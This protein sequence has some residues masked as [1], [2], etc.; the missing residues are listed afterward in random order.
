LLNIN[1]NSK[2]LIYGYGV[3]GKS[4][5]QYLINKKYN[6]KIYDDLIFDNKNKNFINYNKVIKSLTSIDYFIVSPSIKINKSHFLYNFKKKIIID[7][8]FLSIE[9]KN[10][11]IIGITGTEGKSTICSYLHQILSKY[12]NTVIIGNFG[13]TILE[14]KDLSNFLSKTEIIIIELSSYQLDKIQNLKLDYAIITNIYND[15]IKYHSTL[16]KYIDAKLKISSFLIKEGFFFAPKIYIDKKKYPKAIVIPNLSTNKKDPQQ[17]INF[18][19]KK[20]IRVFMKNFDSKINYNDKLL[21]ELSFRNQL[22]ISRKKL[23]IYND[24]KCTNLEN[25]II[26]INLLKNLKKILVLGGI[27]K[28]SKTLPMPIKNTLV[29]IFGVHAEKISNLI[30]LKNSTSIL[31]NRLDDLIDFI[32]ISIKKYN[33]EI[34]LFSPGGES[35]DNYKNY[36]DRGLH[37]NQLL[38]SSKI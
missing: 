17:S 2:F 3:S 24:S 14:K 10:Q 22:V 29:L 12:Y 20:L 34:I 15:H 5:E 37:F 8:D 16:K 21:K 36:A 13:N 9:I 28:V 7:L 25:A 6:F 11:K 19:N 30:I 33:Y 4:I 18:N 27:P 23:K 32:S 1:K 31:F 35:F 38:K 26:K